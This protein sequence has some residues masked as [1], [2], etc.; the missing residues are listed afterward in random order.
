[1]TI[2]R[3]ISIIKGHVPDISHAEVI[4]AWQLL[5]DEGTIW[6]MGAP[7]DKLAACMIEAG[8]LERNAE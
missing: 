4:E 2:S 3:A 8:T 1:M 7:F 5:V 6:R